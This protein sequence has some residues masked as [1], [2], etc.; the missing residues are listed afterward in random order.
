MRDRLSGDHTEFPLPLWERG[1]VRG[2]APAGAEESVA[3]NGSRNSNSTRRL[4]CFHVTDGSRSFRAAARV[5]SPCPS[6]TRGEGTLQDGPASDRCRVRP[7]AFCAL[8]G[9]QSEVLPQTATTTEVSAYIAALT[10]STSRFTASSDVL[11]S[12]LKW[13]VMTSYMACF[14]A[15]GAAW[16]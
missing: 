5:P 14:T 10:A 9:W 11:I 1:R 12:P 7:C 8:A 13:A 6:P 3:D 4:A 16:P 2:P 15:A